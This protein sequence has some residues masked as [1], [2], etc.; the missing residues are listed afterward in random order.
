MRTVIYLAIFGLFLAVS[1]EPMLAQD[2]IV[3]GATHKFACLPYHTGMEHQKSFGDFQD[4]LVES[5]RQKNRQNQEC[6]GIELNMFYLQFL[7]DCPRP[8][9]SVQSRI[10]VQC[11]NLQSPVAR[12][13]LNSCLY[14]DSGDK[15]VVHTRF[16]SENLLMKC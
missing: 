5:S 4:L 1:A 12:G 15:E 2:P 9:S 11:C 7:V 6:T 8:G 16:T 14:K 13:V 3:H 10:D